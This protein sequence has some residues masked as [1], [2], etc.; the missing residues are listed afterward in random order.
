[1]NEKDHAWALFWKGGFEALA[2]RPE[3][4]HWAVALLG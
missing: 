1:M 4:I 3:M 2:R